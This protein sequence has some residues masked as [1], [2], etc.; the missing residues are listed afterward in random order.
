MAWPD[1]CGQAMDQAGQRL[2]AHAGAQCL[3]LP[4]IGDLA[5]P[6]SFGSFAGGHAGLLPDKVGDHEALDAYSLPGIVMNVCN[7]LLSA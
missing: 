1:L 2:L 5:A 4:A 7:A 3:A 6:M